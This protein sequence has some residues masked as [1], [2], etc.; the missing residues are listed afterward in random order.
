MKLQESAFH[1]DTFNRSD[2]CRTRNCSGRAEQKC[3]R[4]GGCQSSDLERSPLP[5]SGG[6]LENSV[7]KADFQPLPA[8]QGIIGF[9]PHNFWPCC[10]RSGYS[11]AVTELRW[12]TI[13]GHPSGKS[14]LTDL[15]HVAHQDIG[16]RR[17]RAWWI[18]YVLLAAPTF[19]TPMLLWAENYVGVGHPSRLVLIGGTAWIMSALILVAMRHVGAPRTISVVGVWSSAYVFMRGGTLVQTLGYGFALLATVAVILGL[20]FLLSRRTERL[21][22]VLLVLASALL[23]V[24]VIVAWYMSIDSL[25]DDHAQPPPPEIEMTLQSKPDIVLIVADAYVGLDGLERYFGVS[26]PAWKNQLLGQGFT[27]PDVAYS[28]YVSTSAAIP[29]IL[30]MAYPIEG[31]PGITKATSRTLYERIGGDNRA[32]RIL[33][34]N[35]YQTTMIE[36][37]WSGSACGD[38]IDKCVPSPFLNESTFFTLNKTWVGPWVLAQYGYSFTVGAL[39]TMTWLQENLGVIT[40]DSKPDLVIAHMEIPH[41]PLFLDSECNLDTSP[42]RSGVTLQWP[43][44]DLDSRKEAYLEQAACFDGFIQSLAKSVSDDS[45]LLI[46]SDHGSDSHHQ[47]ALHPAE[48]SEDAM[49]ERLNVMFAYRGLNECKVEEP[50]LLTN[51][52]RDVLECLADTRIANHEPRMFLYSVLEF[53][54]E[55]SPI[56][57]LSPVVVDKLLGQ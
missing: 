34:S 31:G 45:L 27:V 36:S 23:T 26:D 46:V 38:Q 10:L 19:S 30:D 2:K 24:E 41:P 7:W 8:C 37:G 40:Q 55:P 16:S 4:L 57:E 6:S 51:V 5:R 50:V 12:P 3:E 49:R 42:D 22:E 47:L 13:S 28:P 53:D 21:Q 56:V 1:P 11:A 25:G 43:G 17:D 14:V 18:D 15:N 39:N 52:L 20:C 32:V 48:W 44:V 33:S 35:G 29:A 54:G 9:G